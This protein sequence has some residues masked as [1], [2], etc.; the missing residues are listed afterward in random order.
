M[1]FGEIIKSNSWL[2]IELVLLSLYSDEKK[3]ITG[4]EE[5]FNKL[6]NLQPEETDV[7]IIIS[8]EKDDYGQTDYINVSGY[9]N[10]PNNNTE[11]FTNSLAIE[12]TPWNEWLGMEIDPNTLKT[13]NELEIISHCLYEMT[14]VGFDEKY[15][16]TEIK[17][18][19]DAVEEIENM[20][21][22]EKK[23]KLKSWE[24]LRKELEQ[25]D[26]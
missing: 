6:K 5:V 11:E 22:E 8:W 15:I 7:S 12:F 19:K 2:S 21:E 26:I 20:T 10:N 18:I 16:Q 23:E 3:N 9:Y 13:F 4:Y 17:R 24:E 14:F 25:E 1:K